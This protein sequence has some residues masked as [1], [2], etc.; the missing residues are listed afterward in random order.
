MIL[1]E[2]HDEDRIVEY[3]MLAADDYVTKPFSPRSLLARVHA[4]LRRASLNRGGQ[5]A[6]D[7]LAIGEVALNLQRMHAMVNGH[8]IRLTP[9]GGGAHSGCVRR[10]RQR[11]RR[12]EHPSPA[13]TGMHITVT[14]RAAASYQSVVHQ[15]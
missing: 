13:A 7:N 11:V 10:P 9:L 1:S 12:P 8:P 4:M 3:L 15:A 14:D 6:E 2:L 5:W